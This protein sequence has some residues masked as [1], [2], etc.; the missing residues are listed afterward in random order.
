[1]WMLTLTIEVKGELDTNYQGYAYLL[2]KKMDT[3]CIKE[4]GDG[5]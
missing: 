3:N 2:I 5:S 1:M 4:V